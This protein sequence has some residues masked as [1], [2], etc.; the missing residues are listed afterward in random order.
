[1]Q[2]HQIELVPGE[3]IRVGN[4]IVTLV[5]VEGNAAELHVEE[6]GDD[7]SWSDPECQQAWNQEL[8]LV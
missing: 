8:A 3:S 5:A 6:P 7:S 4:L 1:M 2:L